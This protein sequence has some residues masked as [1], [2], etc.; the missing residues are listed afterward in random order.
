MSGFDALNPHPY[1]PEKP[2]MEQKVTADDGG[3]GGG[4]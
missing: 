2:A 1:L 4:G 3:G